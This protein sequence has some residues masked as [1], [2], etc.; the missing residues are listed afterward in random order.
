[1]LISFKKS[2]SYVIA[3]EDLN[4][5]GAHEGELEQFP[6]RLVCKLNIMIT[7]TYQKYIMLDPA[8]SPPKLQ[9]N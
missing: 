1:M 2:F 4:A 5:T 7:V 9:Q 6:N 3:K 8:S